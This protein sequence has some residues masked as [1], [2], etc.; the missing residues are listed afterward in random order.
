MGQTFVS[1]IFIL[2]LSGEIV[3]SLDPY[4]QQQNGYSAAGGQGKQAIFYPP[5]SN[6]VVPNLGALN[7]CPCTGPLIATG[8]YGDPGVSGRLG[9]LTGVPGIY[10]GRFGALNALG[11]VGGLGGLGAL[12]GLGGGLTALG[13]LGGL[14]GLGALGGLGGIGYPY[15]PLTLAGYGYPYGLGLVN[16]QSRQ[17]KVRQRDD[18][19][20]GTHGQEVYGQQ[21]YA[22]QGPERR[23]KYGRRRTTTPADSDYN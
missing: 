23:N 20:Q 21:R 19:D 15:S 18:D 22:Y 3:S 12:G 4:Q 1:A 2:C 5:R 14:G 6:L 7:G 10:P 17:K 8:G 13:G 16:G 9:A 11:G